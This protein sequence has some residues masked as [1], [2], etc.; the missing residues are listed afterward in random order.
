MQLSKSRYQETRMYCASQRLDGELLKNRFVFARSLALSS[1]KITR[2]RDSASTR[3]LS[4]RTT[5]GRNN[6][7]T[8]NTTSRKSSRLNDVPAPVQE[9]TTKSSVLEVWITYG[10]VLF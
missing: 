5:T 7:E 3:L 1:L 4:T 9:S 8:S 2:L 10:S 6:I